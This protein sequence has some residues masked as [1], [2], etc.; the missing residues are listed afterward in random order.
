ML[1]LPAH[2]RGGLLILNDDTVPDRVCVGLERPRVA[3]KP[4]G[5][6]RLRLV[7][8]TTTDATKTPA[9]GGRLTL[10]V[11]IFPAANEIAAAG[12]DPRTV[13]PLPWLDA[14][15]RLEGPRFD[16]IEAEVSL[17]IGTVSG[18]AGDLSAA[19]AAVLAPLLA[20]DPVSP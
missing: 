10:D 6:S 12:F 13:S 16:P 8:W 7:R 5:S 11:E 9:V 20:A 1:I 15:V 18:A 2:K 3:R 19:G 14:K 4:D 17:A